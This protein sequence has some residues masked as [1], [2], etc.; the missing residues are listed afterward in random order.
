MRLDQIRLPPGFHIELWAAGLPNARSLAL[1]AKGTVFVGTRLA[2][3]VYAVVQR[4]GRRDVKTILN[5]LHRPNGIV[6]HNG[7]LYVAELSRILRYRDI[8]N[9]LDHPG[10]PTVVFDALPK[11]EVHGWKY[12]VMGP[13]GWLYFNIG[14]PCNSCVPPDTHA[15]IVRVDPQKGVMENVVRGVR[16][17]VGMAFHPVTRELW[18]THNGRDWM[19]EDVPHD[20]LN[21]VVRRGQHFGFPYCHQGDLPDPDWGKGRSCG[22]FAPPALKLGAHVAPLGMRFYTGT[23]FPPDYQNRIII[24]NHGSWNRSERAG[25]NLMQ[26]TL[27]AQGKALRY[28]PFAEGWAQGNSHWGRPVDVQVMPDGALLVSDDEAGALFRIS[29]R[30]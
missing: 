22:E 26:V 20:T 2:G 15:S 10:P 28:E 17:S 29:F 8:E 6:F 27:D 1:G 13:D 19:G 21:R 12:M 14:A 11:D 16:N 5:N 23:M 18:F 30:R 24:A 3:A 4:D 9:N 25:F 7:D